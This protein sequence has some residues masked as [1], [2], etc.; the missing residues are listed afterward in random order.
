ME[1]LLALFGVLFVVALIVITPIR[2][3]GTFDTVTNVTVTDMQIKRSGDSDRY[4][5]FTE[6]ANGVREVFKNTDAWLNGKINSSDVWAD[7]SVGDTCT[8]EVNGWRNRL[9]SWYR[10]VLETECTS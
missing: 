5:I 9:F 3:W 4:L 7:V 1:K 6:D 10:N 8:F 2:A